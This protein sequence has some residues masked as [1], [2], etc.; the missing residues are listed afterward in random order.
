M[1]LLFCK[2]I[3]LQQG[4]LL[5]KIQNKVHIVLIAV[6]C[7]LSFCSCNSKPKFSGGDLKSHM[8]DFSEPM[9]YNEESEIVDS[10][11][12]NITYSIVETDVDNKLITLDV[13]VPD[14]ATILKNTIDEN[15]DGSNPDDYDALLEYVKEKFDD[16][17]NDPSHPT[18]N[19]QI[20]LSIDKN[21]NGDWK[22]IPNDEFYNFIC[23][24]I[25][26][27]MEES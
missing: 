10:Y 9:K 22:I 8:S 25:I 2:T 6:F 19:K 17:L 1:V 26:L 5:M 15:Y 20:T 14:F 16:E 27:A 23:E 18:L 3:N 13:N 24:P 7:L 12:R 11:Y 4:E 21:K